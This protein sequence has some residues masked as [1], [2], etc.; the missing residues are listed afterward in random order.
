MYTRVP[1]KKSSKPLEFSIPENYAGNAFNGAARYNGIFDE[2]NNNP[3]LI[4]KDILPEPSDIEPPSD[5]IDSVINT[6]SQPKEISPPKNEIS[7]FIPF[8]TAKSLKNHFPFGHGIG[9]EE[10][11]ILGIMTLL[12]TSEDDSS[13]DAELIML[14]ALLLFAG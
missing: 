5:S 6:A 13:T 8:A 11:L 14:L 12:F 4:A 2:P 3:E 9:S 1:D 10:L 7:Q